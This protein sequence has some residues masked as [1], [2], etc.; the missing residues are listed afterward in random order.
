MAKS[1]YRHS[2]IKHDLPRGINEPHATEK[3]SAL[4]MFMNSRISYFFISPFSEMKIS[5]RA[6]AV[7]LARIAPSQ[8]AV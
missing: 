8:R 6:P 1:V 4:V 7:K 5:R 3:D 2:V